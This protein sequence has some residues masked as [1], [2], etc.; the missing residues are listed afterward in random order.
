ATAFLIA[1]GVLP[2]NEGRG[3]VLRR[4]MRRAMRHAFTLGSD[5]PVLY[6][7][8]PTLISEM[9]SEYPELKRADSLISENLKL[10]EERFSLML[11]NGMK[12]LNTEIVNVKNKKLSG[13][14]AFKLYDT[15]GFPL[16]LTQDFLKDKNISVDESQ[17]N[18][19]MLESK[20]TARASWKG[21]G[22]DQ[23]SKIWFEL[24]EKYGPTE[25]LGYNSESSQGVILSIV[26]I[27]K[28]IESCDNHSELAIILNQTPFYGESGGQVGDKGF[29]FNNNFKFEV[30]D[31]KKMFMTPKAAV[32]EGALA[33]FGEKYGE[34]VRVLTMGKDGNKPFSIELCGGT[35]VKNTYEIGRFSVVSQ[36]PVA[37]GVR[38]V[39]ALRDTQLT[40]YLK[41][42]TNELDEINKNK[43][44][45][46]NELEKKIKDLGGN[47]NQ[48]KEEDFSARTIILKRALEDLEVKNIL[49]NKSKNIIKDIIHNK[50]N[51]RFQKLLDYP[52]KRIQ[53]FI[54][55]Q[56][57][58]INN[59]II[60]L[61]SVN[62]G[63][64][65]VAVGITN[66]L[67]DK[68]DASKLAKEIGVI[69]GG[70][71]GG[72]RKD[73]AQA[74]GGSDSSK[75]DSSFD[76]ILKKIN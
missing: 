67:A 13:E 70:K 58:L 69:L 27:N 33:L 36:S 32:A 68:Y 64:V 15:Y 55:D 37:A 51:I 54:E 46:I 50:I 56:K 39:E 71:G 11:K 42:R 16:D 61:Y 41:N 4:I 6:K 63:K 49:L 47:I 76:E 7:V 28:E 38:R 53:N 8:L 23:T 12:I 9:S 25:F 1:D 20:K 45:Q 14:L 24:K 18:V 30:T 44:S 74:S 5:L 2:S 62:E 73:F 66:D 19:L 40:E 59:K 29:I 72:G 22:S 34:E 3:Y 26:N 48:I 10:E 52:V 21:S 43:I 17:F 31:T 57:K 60:I 35:H 75:I 65:T